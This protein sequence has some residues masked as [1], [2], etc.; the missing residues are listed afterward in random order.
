MATLALRES[1][2]PPSRNGSNKPMAPL[3]PSL[4]A[5]KQLTDLFEALVKARGFKAAESSF[6]VLQDQPAETILDVG[7][8]QYQARGNARR[9]TL[10][11]ELLA[12]SGDAG[13]QCL[14]RFLDAP[15][16][17]RSRLIFFVDAI[18]GSTSFTEDQRR[19][20]LIRVA[21]M[22]DADTADRLSEIADSLASDT[23]FALRAVLSKRG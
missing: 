18:A 21:R 9:L 4:P 3:P 13:A 16:M 2:A 7:L 10:T 17:S 15:T 12:A 6:R 1:I 11:A 22:A 20:L 19:E 14:V 8:R 23:A 5:E